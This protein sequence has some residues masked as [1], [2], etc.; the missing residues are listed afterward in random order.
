MGIN[1][2]ITA[3]KKK[4]KLSLLLGRE[5]SEG[6]CGDSVFLINICRT[7]SSLIKIRNKSTNLVSKLQNSYKQDDPV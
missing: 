1:T 5:K 2:K 7:L 6:G 4:Q 3:K